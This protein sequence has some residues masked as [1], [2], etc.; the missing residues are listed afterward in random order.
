MLFLFLS[1]LCV[2]VLFVSMFCYSEENKNLF[3][4]VVEEKKGGKENGGQKKKE[5]RQK[6]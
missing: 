3:L 1:F 4:P 2:H 6:I 5:V